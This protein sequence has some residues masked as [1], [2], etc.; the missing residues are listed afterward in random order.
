MGSEPRNLGSVSFEAFDDLVKLNLSGAF[1][2]LR[3]VLAKSR[4]N[5]G[6][7][8]IFS[9]VAAFPGDRSTKCVVTSSSDLTICLTDL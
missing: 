3:G 9:S 5:A 7:A 4:T 8:V 2:L 6:D 1:Y